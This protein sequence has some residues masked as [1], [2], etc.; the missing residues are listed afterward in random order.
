MKY[1]NETYN[2]FFKELAA[3]NNRDW[4]HANKSRYE[5]EVK[6]TFE[7]FVADLISE[8]AKFEPQMKQLQPKDAIFRIFRDT[9]FS[10]DKTPYKLFSSAVFSPAGKKD[11]EMPGTYLQFGVG[12]IWIGGGAYMPYK[13][14]IE[15]IRT[16]MIQSPETIESLQSDKEFIK[17]FGELRGEKNK[18]L[19]KPFSEWVDKMPLIANKQFYYMAEYNDDETIILRDDILEYVMEHYLAA[20]HWQDF[21][22]SALAV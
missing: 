13:E 12:E 4:Y 10:Q 1:F 7:A 9:R 22:R 18:R 17:Y 16:A 11:I 20:K 3:N 6:K 15:K 8:I 21:L 5:K 2:S 19:L 14:Q